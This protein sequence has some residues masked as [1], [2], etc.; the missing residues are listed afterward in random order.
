MS[1]KG[2]K[3]FPDNLRTIVC[4]AGNIRTTIT[5]RIFF[6]DE[7]AKAA[8]P[9]WACERVVSPEGIELKEN[10]FIDSHLVYNAENQECLRVLD[11]FPEVVDRGHDFAREALIP[12]KDVKEFTVR[13]VTKPV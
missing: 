13:T 8:V 7:T 9:H 3:L 5:A 4:S 11:W 10:L 1:N 6:R 2:G 12:W